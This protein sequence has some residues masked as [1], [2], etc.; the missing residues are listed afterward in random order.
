MAR[1]RTLENTRGVRERSVGVFQKARLPSFAK[2]QEEFK[3]EFKRKMM[4]RCSSGSPEGRKKYLDECTVELKKKTL[5]VARRLEVRERA[6][7][8]EEDF[9]SRR[10][11]EWERIFGVS[12]VP[13]S[14]VLNT[15]VR[16]EVVSSVE[17]TLS[18]YT[19]SNDPHS[20]H[21]SFVW[22]AERPHTDSRSMLD[23]SVDGFDA[24]DNFRGWPGADNIG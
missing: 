15:A 24:V 1:S 13:E 6:K 21:V 10:R 7:M 19:L 22:I 11:T 4:T 8:G 18:N 2:E 20:G 12:P 3:E 9:S 14:C 5:E 17:T 23:V 16:R